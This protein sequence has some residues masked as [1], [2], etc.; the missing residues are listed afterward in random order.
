MKEKQI[1]TK[2]RRFGYRIKRDVPIVPPHFIENYLVSRSHE[3]DKENI[4][5]KGTYFRSLW[6]YIVIVCCF[7]IK[8]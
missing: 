4:G 2:K 1:E 7:K 5:M 6:R 3:T 8:L